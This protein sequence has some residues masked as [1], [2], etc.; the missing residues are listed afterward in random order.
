[1]IPLSLLCGFL[2]KHAVLATV[3]KTFDK[4]VFPLST[5]PKTP[6]LKLNMGAAIFFVFENKIKTESGF[7]AV[8][9]YQVCI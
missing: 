3:L 6:T 5:C 8:K 2:S 7:I 4:L 9:P 1:V